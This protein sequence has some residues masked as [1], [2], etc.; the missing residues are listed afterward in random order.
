MNEQ[1]KIFM[2]G[3]RETA[4]DYLDKFKTDFA[5]NPTNA[6]GK[7][8]A[9]DL[10]FDQLNVYSDLIY[11]GML[12]GGVVK[13]GMLSMIK[14]TQDV[15]R[16]YNSAVYDAEYNVKLVLSDIDYYS[17]LLDEQAVNNAD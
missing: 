2:N 7:V 1:Q 5:G 8:S 3:L 6:D 10:F 13:S 12:G 15:L 17:K 11:S 16:T 9:N 14:N 4:T